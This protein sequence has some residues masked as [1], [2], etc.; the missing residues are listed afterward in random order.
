VVCIS[1]SYWIDDDTPC[2][3]YGLRG[4][5]HAQ[6]EVGRPDPKDLHS[7]VDGGATD[8]PLNDLIKVLSKLV[9]FDKKILIPGFNDCVRPVAEQEREMY[10]LLGSKCARDSRA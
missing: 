5:I 9:A 3:T 10:Q 2:L 4:V 1:N 7:G 8:E 6:V